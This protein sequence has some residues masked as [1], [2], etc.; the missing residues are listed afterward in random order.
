MRRREMLKSG[1]AISAAAGMAWQGMAY[2]AAQATGKAKA[3]ASGGSAGGISE[4][5]ASW[6]AMLDRVCRPLF[7]AL[8]ERRLKAVMPVEAYVG[9]QQH[10]RQTTYLEALGR[11]LTGL[12]PWL[13]HGATEGDEGKLRDRYCE[14]ART[15]I[16]SAV[17]KKSPDYMDFGGDR[18]TIVD[19][20]FLS[21]AMLRAPREL[22]EKL[23][24]PVR[25][26]LAD[27]LRATRT[28]LAPFNNWLLFAAT[29]EA[30]LYALGEPWDRARVDYALR[31]HANWYVGDGVYGDGPHF[32]QDYYNSFV[33]QPFLTMLMDVVGK[34][35]DAW[36]AMAT[37]I[38]ARATRYAAI[39]E[40][41]IA[42][43]GTYPV[44]GRSIAYRCGAFQ[45]LADAALRRTL[46]VEV[47]PEQVRGALTAV[48][49]R[50]LAAPGT[51]DEQGWLRI[52]LA[53][54][55]PSLGEVYISTGSLYLCTAA[56]LPLGLP[57]GDRFWSGAAA[58]WS[59]V[60]VWS[61]ADVK[62]DHAL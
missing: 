8:S 44:V 62:A 25:A 54:H 24:A 59:S 27:A 13:E 10:R 46:P 47:S 43:D 23:P 22:R 21:L 29:I 33:I 37:D 53:G 7:V 34:Q 19:T 18:Q 28:Q 1:L 38:R 48:M 12:A 4:E 17:D 9:E 58:P 60:K 45:Q 6:V 52:G 11:A 57:A 32:H 31:E 49:R 51:F 15:G 55:Q 61:G 50:T 40:R 41:M 16:A 20:A 42:P 39:Q 14:W 26:Q 2:R 35:E 30:G 56:F 3:V 5:R 36:A